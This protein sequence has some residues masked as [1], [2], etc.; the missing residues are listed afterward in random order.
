MISLTAETSL[1]LL[2]SRIANHTE[3][4]TEMTTTEKHTEATIRSRAELNQDRI[5]Y[6]ILPSQAAVQTAV[7]GYRN[8]ITF[9]LAY[10]LPYLLLAFG[11]IFFIFLGLN[12]PR[13]SALAFL[14]GPLFTLAGFVA[15]G[16]TLYNVDPTGKGRSKGFRDSVRA[17]GTTIVGVGSKALYTIDDDG[18]R[19]MFFD[20]IGTIDMNEG[21][22]SFRSRFGEP[23]FTQHHVMTEDGR[24]IQQII[25]DLATRAERSRTA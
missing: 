13:G 22:I 1:V 16:M 7:A 11:G 5:D 6:F 15:I 3:L 19:A 23:T 18:V 4:A 24:S 25:A 9:G 12:S 8:T 14:I 20:A 2:K 21:S 10:I 17:I